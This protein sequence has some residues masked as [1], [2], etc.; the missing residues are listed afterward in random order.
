MEDLVL[1]DVL[2]A[3]ADLQEELPDF[4]LLQGLLVL[5]LQEH[6]QVPVVT[7]LHHDM[8]SAILDERILILNDERVD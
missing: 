5:C 4:L 3:E 7:I 1:V 6:R 8:Q 2:K